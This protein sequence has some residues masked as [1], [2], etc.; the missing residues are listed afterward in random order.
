M[1]KYASPPGTPTSNAILL[2][3]Y[4]ITPVK[5]VLNSSLEVKEEKGRLRVLYVS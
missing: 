5:D 2:A 4:N 1:N 3:H